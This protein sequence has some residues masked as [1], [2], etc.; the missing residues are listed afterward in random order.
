VSE[1]RGDIIDITDRKT[2][3]LLVEKILI[4]WKATLVPLTEVLIPL[5]YVYEKCRN[6]YTSSATAR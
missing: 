5:P 4:L 6:G 2:R 3:G 1:K